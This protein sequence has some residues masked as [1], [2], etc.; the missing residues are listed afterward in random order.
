MIDTPPLRPFQPNAPD[1]AGVISWAHIGDLHMTL[2]GEHNHRDLLLIV[3][4]INA[5]FSENLAFVYIPGDVAD[6][7]SVAEYEVV[8]EA[9]DVPQSAMVLYR[10]GP[11]RS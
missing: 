9:L 4:E 2:A 6:K 7:G 8:R 3:E 1:A 10:W 11:R 5:A